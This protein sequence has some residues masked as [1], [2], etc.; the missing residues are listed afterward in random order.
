MCRP[1]CGEMTE[2]AED[3]P[4]LW[5]PAET[6]EVRKLTMWSRICSRI[7]RRSRP[8]RQKRFLS[9]HRS[10]LKEAGNEN[11]GHGERLAQQVVPFPRCYQISSF[12]Y[13]TAAEQ[14]KDC[15]VRHLINVDIADLNVLPLRWTTS[16]FQLRSRAN[17]SLKS[18]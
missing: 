1:A 8:G 4:K 11:V 13:L 9:C 17:L 6:K 10:L 3:F 7:L 12:P 14:I 2:E 5:M 16:S 15:F 18:W